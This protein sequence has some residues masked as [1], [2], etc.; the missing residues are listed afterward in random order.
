MYAPIII[1]AFNRPD[2]FRDTVNALK[3]NP[4]ISKFDLHVFIDGPRENNAF[5]R[6]TVGEVKN[7]AEAIE[8]FNTVTL[9]IS[10]SNKGLGPSVISGVSEVLQANEQAIILEDDLIVQP[11]FLS[12]INAGLKKYKS[13]QRVFSICGYTNKIIVPK[14]YP[15][16]SYFCT[17]S[18]SW[19][20]ATWRDR[21]ESVDWS[22]SCWDEW[23]RQK[24]DFNKW[25]GSDCFSMLKGCKDGVNKSWAIRFCFNQFLQ[26]KL[27]LFPI[28]SLVSNNGFDG[29][30]TNC[31]RYS[32]FKFELFNP[33]VMQF[34]FPETTSLNNTIY[35]SA[36]RYNGLVLRIFSK[37]MYSLMR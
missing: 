7:I 8:G 28:K 9:H 18:S 11:N 21:W 26:N 20:W 4:G 13:D 23:S 31:K 22:F 19:G 29:M 2:S 35:R 14:D 3:N 15:F 25:G 10:K 34:S 36:M 5:D 37:I 6:E 12:F 32:R 27:S 30:G 33:N 16:D 1:F 24:K 17:R